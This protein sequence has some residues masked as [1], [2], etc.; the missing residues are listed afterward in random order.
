MMVPGYHAGVLI[1]L[2]EQTGTW[3]LKVGDQ[4][5]S[6]KAKSGGINPSKRFDRK[7]DT[8]SK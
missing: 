7:Q 6:R 5:E 1:G 8:H 2:F 4:Y 3:S